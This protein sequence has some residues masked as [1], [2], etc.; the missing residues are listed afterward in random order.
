MELAT[1]VLTVVGWQVNLSE[2]GDT[3]QFKLG[4]PFLPFQQLLGVLPPLSS[5]LLPA[6]YR[7]L[8]TNPASPVIEFFTEELKL[9]MEGKSFEWEAIVLLQFMDEAK[10]LSAVD[11][12]RPEQL[13][14]EERQQ[15]ILGT[16]FL[17]HYDPSVTGSIASPIP[18]VLS[19]ITNASCRV[20][21]Y[22]MQPF[23]PGVTRFVPKLC[24]GVSIGR[25]CVPGWPTTGCHYLD[26]VGELTAVGVNVFGRPSSRDSMQ[27]SL[28]ETLAKGVDVKL[29]PIHCSAEE[30]VTKHG[31]LGTSRW[32]NF[33]FL[34]ESLVV[35]VCDG[36]KKYRLETVGKPHSER[37]LQA[38][39][40]ES[41]EREA[42]AL[43][44][45]H[46]LRWA[47]DVGEVRVTVDLR[48]F[49]GMKRAAGG[50]GTE[51]VR[52]K[53]YTV[54]NVHQ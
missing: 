23:P 54:A 42:S 21:P 11:M 28:G 32:A 1:Y 9:D 14:D 16:D 51:K 41:W 44:D 43:G 37:G 22:H 19:N 25:Q 20:S 10:L 2:L 35:G 6:P 29:E 38:A 5:A 52:N 33:P 3:S 31:L 15:N 24:D 53:S 46:K 45:A 27:L 48:L 17:F 49:I 34:V 30:L 4:V 13:T 47:V 12:V 26:M 36:V 50:L 40:A 39:E 7:A 8:M 18:Q